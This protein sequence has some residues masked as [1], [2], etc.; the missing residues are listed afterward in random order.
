MSNEINSYFKKEINPIRVRFVLYNDDS[1]T[2]SGNSV[3]HVFFEVTKNF[4]EN[5]PCKAIGFYGES[6]EQSKDYLKEFLN[7]AKMYGRL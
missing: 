5:F 1:I 3:H 2:V 4:P 6:E 7:L